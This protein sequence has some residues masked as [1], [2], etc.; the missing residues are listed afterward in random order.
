MAHKTSKAIKKVGTPAAALTLNGHEQTSLRILLQ[1]REQANAS[2][3]A[4]SGFVRNYLIQL[5]QERGLD[6]N[7]WGISPDMKSFTEIK[8][9]EAAP[10]QPGQPAAFV[11]P[12]VPA[13]A[14]PA[15]AKS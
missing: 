6:P 2:L 15:P 3:A 8:Q 10:V 1:A 9:P 13:A 5:L 7:K 11:Q 12:G 4:A 14:A